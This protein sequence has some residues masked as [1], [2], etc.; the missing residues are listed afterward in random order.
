M[1]FRLHY[2][3]SPIEIDLSG[4]SFEV[5]EP[6][7]VRAGG[8][9]PEDEILKKAINTR[10]L[11]ELVRASGRLTVI[12]N[13]CQRP[14]P[15]A[16][17][18]NFI[19]PLLSA[20]KPNFIVACGAHDPP[21]EDE[22]A[23]IFGELLPELRDRIHIHRART[24][25]C[26]P[27]TRSKYGFDFQLNELV[28]NSDTIIAINS[29]EPH[30]FAGFTG[31]RKSFLPGV[32]SYQTIVENHKMSLLPEAQTLALEGNPV[33]ENMMEC[34]RWMNEH[35]RLYSIQVVLRPDRTLY[36]VYAGDMEGSFYRAVKDARELYTCPFEK[37]ADIV[38]TV[39]TSPQDE[40]LYQ[41]FKPLDNGSLALK[42]GGVLILVA[43]CQ[44]GVGNDEFVEKFERFR[45]PADVLRSRD[46]TLEAYQLGYQRILR[47]ARWSKDGRLFIVT[48]M[49][50]Q[51]AQKLFFR[52][53]VS[54]SEALAEARRITRPQ[55]HVIVIPDGILT[56]PCR[57]LRGEAD[58]KIGSKKLK[59]KMERI[60]G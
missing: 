19:Y 3:P 27:I 28:V 2:K 50:R 44:R 36:S 30:Y 25:K 35:Y 55:P 8:S 26:I 52:P 24:D 37:S 51:V 9:E 6:R 15:T 32:A 38:I 47:L 59:L 48:N 39:S 56:V 12:V 18:L 11:S 21:T 29:V 4:Y 43:G 54:I 46:F 10:Y 53:F 58:E 31:G 13:D 16:K 40:R 33:H 23:V 45:S 20:R 17:I 7:S 60:E 42:E 34:A 5:L 57:V 14:T 22:L 41:S 49:D 1:R